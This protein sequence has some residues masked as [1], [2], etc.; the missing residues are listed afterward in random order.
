MSTNNHYAP[1]VQLS[2]SHLGYQPDSPKL[3]TMTATQPDGLPAEVPFY[4]RQNCF[5]MARQAEPM[6]GFSARFPSPYHTLQGAL[7]PPRE[8]SYFYRGLL[9][10]Q[11]TR[12]GTL[13]QAD[14]SDW[15][16]PGSFQIETDTQ[17]SVPFAVMTRQYDRVLLGYLRFLQAQRCGCDVFGVHPACHLDDGVLE[18]DG[19]SWPVTGGWH[20]AGD[21]RKWMFFT[22]WHLQALATLVERRGDDLQ[23]G[24]IARAAVLD[25]IRWGNRFFHGMITDAGQVYEDVAGGQAPANSGLNYDEHWWFENHPGVYGN[26]SDN[27][28]TD[29][30]PHSGDERRVRTSY[31]PFVQFA[32]VACQARVA[33]LLNAEEKQHCLELAL[34]AWRYGRQRGHDGR[35]LFLT[36]ELLAA[37]E[38]T[39]QGCNEVAVADVAALAAQLLTHQDSGAAGLHS[40]FMEPGGEAYRSIGFSADP[41]LA[42]LRLLEILPTLPG[43]PEKLSSRARQAVERY[44]DGFLLADAASNPYGLTPYGIYIMRE[45]PQRQTFRDAGRGRGVRTFMAPFNRMGVA[46]GLNGLWMNHAHLLTRAAVLLQRTDWRSAA[47]R[48]LHWTFGHNPFNRSTSVS[49]GF[50]QPIGYSFRIP[51]LPEAI[52]AGCI[53]WPDDSP[54]LEESAAIEWNTLEYWG[55]P[56]LNAAQ[57]VC[58]L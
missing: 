3:L 19:S 10:R 30:V 41:A 17:V 16:T 53:G 31:N 13:W 7:K 29:N 56:Y 40:Y 55:I 5:R 35:T 38:L 34:R 12:W 22:L 47:E 32:F 46:H 6:E 15:T 1:G 25:E 23:R 18:H 45:H 51:Q 48:L 39:R 27:R 44:I 42:L 49:I 33:P 54:Y 24:G 50:H 26:A 4:L 11:A 20:D 57:A 14:F 58:Y 8:S 28:W 43:L 36:S 2:L 9:R 52:M 21:F 37:L